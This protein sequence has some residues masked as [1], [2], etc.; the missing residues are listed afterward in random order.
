[1]NKKLKKVEIYADGACS[2]NPGP[3]GY[4]VVLICGTRR[5]ELSGGFRLTTNSRMEIMG[6]IAGLKALKN[7]CTVTLH[8]DSK[9]LVDSMRLGWAKRWEVNGWKRNKKEKA[10]NPDLWEE[11]LDLCDQH[12]V[13]FV[14]LKGHAD[15]PENERCD[16]LAVQASQRMD[17]PPDEGYEKRI[18]V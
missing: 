15:H 16:D 4:G 13:E 18:H 8:S 14:W 2:G 3:G 12:E 7:T 10:Q 17:R 5:R 1:M 6:A 11:L 9:Y